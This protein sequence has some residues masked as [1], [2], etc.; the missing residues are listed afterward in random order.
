M[1]LS[2]QNKITAVKK[3]E[4]EHFVDSTKPVWNYSLFTDEDIT[5]FQA[6]THYSLYKLFGSHYL[7]VLNRDGYYFSVWA[8]NATK[9]SVVGDFNNW[10]NESHPLFVR[11]EKS[12]IWEGFIPG[13]TEYA[14][15]KYYIEGFDG[16]KLYKGDPYANHWEVRPGTASKTI[17]L[18]HLWNDDEWMQKRKNHN[19]LNAPWSV[20]EVHL[21]SWMRPFPFNEFSLNS[22]EQTTKLLVPYVKKLGFTHVELMPVME[23]P[24]DGSWGYQGTG[25]FAPT[26]RYGVPEEFMKMIEAFHKEDIGVILDWVPSHFPHDAFGLYMFDGTHTYEYADMR[27]GYHP[28]WNSYIFNYK[29]AEVRSFLISSARFWFDKFHIDGIRVDAVSSMLRLDYSREEGEWEPNEFGGNGNLEAFAFIKDL[30]A[31][32]YRDFPDVQ[33]IAEESTNQPQVTDLTVNGGLGFGMK[34]MMGWMHDTLDYFKTDPLYRKDQ[35]D[36]FTFSMMYFYDENFMLPLSHDEVVHGKS[37]MIYKMPGDDWQKF[38]NLRLLYTY[39]FTHP[40]GKLL[41]MGNEIAQTTEWNYETEVDWHLLVH[42]PHRKMQDCVSALNRLYT[43]QP[44]LYENQFD[45]EGFEW[46]NL[47]HRNE[48]VIAYMRKGK[49]KKDNILALF[50]MTPVTREN[51]TINVHGKKE[52]QVIF[53]SDNKQY[54]GGGYFDEQAITTTLVDKKS[55]LYE[56][57]LHLPALGAIVLK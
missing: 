14:S 53:N 41:F 43:G 49:K 32:V 2:H 15:Y 28:D 39:M 40:G 10:N 23:Y 25:Y 8:P 12:G 48:C 55:K 6:G 54:Y 42:E 50:N 11:L 52:W 21:A 27:K 22:Y 34:W 18:N 33:M 13:I 29:R 17:V 20:Y 26:S 9:V 7:N 4:E 46:I 19:D 51:W 1:K 16:V 24:F 47:D 45:E 35:Q 36:K 44:A 31:M 56:I 30:N 57:K 38:A 3:Y 37:P 5:N